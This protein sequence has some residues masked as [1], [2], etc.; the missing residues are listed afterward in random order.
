M[1]NCIERK[2]KQFTKKNISATFSTKYFRHPE[3]MWHIEKRTSK[4][5]ETLD[6]SL[7]WAKVPKL[8]IEH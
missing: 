7:L 4:E 5:I 3:C 8:Y 1:Q 6:F 2:S